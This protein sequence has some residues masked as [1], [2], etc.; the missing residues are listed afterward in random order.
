MEMIKKVFLNKK[1]RKY[2]VV[3]L[4]MALIFYLSSQPA[5]KS[6]NLILKTNSLKYWYSVDGIEWKEAYFPEI[7]VRGRFGI[8]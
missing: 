3:I 4:W 1:I 5:E 7:L 2:L 8:S 6:N